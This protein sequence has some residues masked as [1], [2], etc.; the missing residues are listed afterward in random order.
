[1]SQLP[2]TVQLQA[3][4]SWFDDTRYSRRAMLDEMMRDPIYDLF[5]EDKSNNLSDTL[6]SNGIDY[7]GI[8]KAKTPGGRV[9][10]DAPIEVDTHSVGYITFVKRFNYELESIL[11]DQYK[12]LDPDGTMCI[13]QLWEA[14]G[15]FLTNALWNEND[16]TSFEVL[17]HEG[18][19]NYLTGCPDGKSL[20]AADHSGPGYS[21]KTNIG[22]TGPLTGPNVVTNI[23][24]GKTNFCFPSGQPKTYR[25][26]LIMH[27]D[28]EVLTEAS[29]Q[30]TGSTK[31]ASSANNAVNIYSDGSKDV[32]VF[33]HAPRVSTTNLRSSTAA[34]VYKWATASRSLMK[35]SIR[36]KWIAKPQ[37]IGEKNIDDENLDS[38]ATA[39]CRLAVIIDDPFFMV[40]NTA[41]TAPTTAW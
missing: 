26:D 10:K 24:I 19:I 3:F 8:A 31:V 21:N 27:G 13:K 29:R 35:Q 9:V 41:T 37:L 32:V 30:I 16:G 38:F 11:H 39:F 15:L 12:L 7:S 36:L 23:D 34:D 18:V 20:I 4:R 25:P 6:S 1:M 5:G 22:G 28:V 2:S 14:V 17:A 33:K 40:Q